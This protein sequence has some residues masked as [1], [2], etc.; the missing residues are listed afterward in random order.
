MGW[1][2][3]TALPPPPT[4][5]IDTRHSSGLEDC[6][7]SPSTFG[8]QSRAKGHWLLPGLAPQV[9]DDRGPKAIEGLALVALPPHE[10]FRIGAYGASRIDLA[11]AKFAPA[12]AELRTQRDVVHPECTWSTCLEFGVHPHHQKGNA[13]MKGDRRE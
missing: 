10:R 7:P 13:T 11:V 4:R 6:Q 8:P 5:L 9:C 2:T 3:L 12:A 1:R